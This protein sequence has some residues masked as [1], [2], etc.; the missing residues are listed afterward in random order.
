MKEFETAYKGKNIIVTVT[1]WFK[2][3]WLSSWLNKLG[4]KCIRYLRSTSSEIL[5]IIKLSD[6][7]KKK[8]DTE[9]IGIADTKSALSVIWKFSPD[10]IFHLAALT[11]CLYRL[12]EIPVE[13]YK[14]I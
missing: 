6:Q 4:V 14:T 7:I 3:S 12:H 5:Q 2:G 1:Y 8:I 11:N 10:Y 13:T 9:W